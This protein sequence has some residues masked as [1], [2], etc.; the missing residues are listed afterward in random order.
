MRSRR[1]SPGG[2]R[3]IDRGLGCAG[4]VW[5]LVAVAVILFGLISSLEAVG[6]G[7]AILL[8]EIGAYSAFKLWRRD[9]GRRS[10]PIDTGL[11]AGAVLAVAASVWLLTH[12]NKL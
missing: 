11:A 4:A 6:A 2:S 12:L 7:I 1:A 10:I 3:W 8:L 9:G 5:L